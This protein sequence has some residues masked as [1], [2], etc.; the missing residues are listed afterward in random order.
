MK[1]KWSEWQDS[2]PRPP[3][4]RP[5]ALKTELRSEENGGPEGTCTL[6]LPADNGLLRIELRVQMVGS[7]GNAPLVTSGFVL[8]HPIYSRA[9]GS[10]PAESWWLSVES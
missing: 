8:R 4:P 7:G 9:A 5:G 10:L 1:W 3:G 2:H 6:S